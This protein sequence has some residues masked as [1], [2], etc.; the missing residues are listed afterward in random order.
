MHWDWGLIESLGKTV[1]TLIGVTVAAYS[2]YRLGVRGF[3]SRV[4]LQRDL[5]IL[6]MLD[7]ADPSHAILKS[8]VDGMIQT[9]YAPR[10]PSIRN[11]LPKHF[12]EWLK[13]LKSHLPRPKVP[14]LLL[15]AGLF[16][17]FSLWT[18]YLNDRAPIGS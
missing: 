18:A 4:T 1:G 13:T 2:A 9:L 16:F 6:K 12:K 14:D 17:G 10:A 5:E 3:R 7:P 8:Y 15:G 11:R